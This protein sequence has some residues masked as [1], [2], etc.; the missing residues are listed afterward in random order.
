MALRQGHSWCAALRGLFAVA[1]SSALANALAKPLIRRHR[2]SHGALPGWRQL[3]APPTSSAFPSRH[4]VSAA[5]FA[6]AVTMEFPAAGAVVAGA[7]RSAGQPQLRSRRPGRLAH[8]GALL[9]L[10]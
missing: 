1:G 2:P 6:T 8:P 7:T 5:A 9:H 10:R 4:S 3:A